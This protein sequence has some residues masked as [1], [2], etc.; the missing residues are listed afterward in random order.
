M[1]ISLHMGI[2]R[3]DVFLDSQLLATQLNNCYR[4]HDPFLLRKLFLTRHLVRHFESISFMHVPII[5]NI[6]VNQMANDV[7]EWHINHHI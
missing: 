7:L 3:F 2:H 5:L 6:V 1:A 4:V